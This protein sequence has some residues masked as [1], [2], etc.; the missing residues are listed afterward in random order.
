MK[1]IKS[2]LST[3]FKNNL[4][5][6][7]ITIIFLAIGITTGSYSIKALNQLQRSDLLQYFNNFIKIAKEQ[8][9]D[10][11]NLFFISLRNNY[12]FVL[13]MWLFG[14]TYIGIPVL[15]GLITLKGFLIGYTV[16]FIIDEMSLDG[17]AFSTAAVLPQNLFM[18]PGY[19]LLCVNCM[20]FSLYIIKRHKNRYG[21]LMEKIA[22]Y[23]VSCILLSLIILAGSVIEAYVVPYLIKLTI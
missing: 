7:I 20:V 10:S 12:I 4:F 8:T 19:I 13:A 23:S 9:I 3:Y 14:M 18:I 11:Q 2:Y 16:G 22:Q 6:Y 15:I 21:S 17:I 5:L 1:N